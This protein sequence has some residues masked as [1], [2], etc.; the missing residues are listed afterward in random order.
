M[1]TVLKRIFLFGIFII[2]VSTW[3]GVLAP[4]DIAE[5]LDGKYIVGSA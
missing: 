3:G 5:L 4:H 1:S 2:P